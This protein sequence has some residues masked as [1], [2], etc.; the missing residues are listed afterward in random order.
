MPDIDKIPE[1]L[2]K[3]TDPYHFE[4]DNIPLD[5]ILQRQ[6]VINSAVDI[7]SN[8]LRDAIGTEGTLAN[9]LD[10]SINPDG[11]LKSS[12][13]DEAEHNIG[14][15]TDGEFDGID[16]VRMT[17][18]ERD[19]LALISDEAT[20]LKLQFNTV[21]ITALF[22]DETVEI[23]DSDTITWSLAGDSSVRAD[24]AFPAS[25]AHLHFY[26]LVPTHATPTLPNFKDYKTTTVSTPFIDGSLRVHVNGIR[27]T[28]GVGIFVPPS[29][30][31]DGTW[32]LT[33]FMGTATAGTFTL[34]RA[35]DISDIIRIDFDTGF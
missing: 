5:Q 2:H 32:T 1:V 4:F 20:A 15:H 26:D 17:E 6:D 34:N 24:M 9:R 33:Y 35:L 13:V 25:A 7:N 14:A 3:A 29:T 28:E 18:S 11:T 10:I 12:A 22:E 21:S 27:L 8:I 19:K 16:Y 23:V 31:P 30:G